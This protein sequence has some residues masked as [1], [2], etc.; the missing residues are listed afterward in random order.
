[1]NLNTIL[2]ALVGKAKKSLLYKKKEY[3]KQNK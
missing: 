1:M 2:Q 3:L